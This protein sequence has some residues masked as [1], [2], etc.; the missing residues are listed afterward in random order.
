MGGEATAG[1]VG[2]GAFCSTGWD[3]AKVS[4]SVGAVRTD[5]IS[6]KEW[7][8]GS[9]PER[10]PAGSLQVVSAVRTAG[11]LGSS[12]RTSVRGS[13]A[14]GSSEAETKKADWLQTGQV[15]RVEFS[16]AGAGISQ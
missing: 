2:G 4:C 5:G 7:D 16:V 14:F 6:G 15:G 8:G 1:T 3:G 12:G 11:S 9:S 13:P 10:A